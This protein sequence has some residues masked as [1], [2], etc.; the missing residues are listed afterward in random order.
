MKGH[1][2]RLRL[3]AAY[4]ASLGPETKVSGASL[5]DADGATVVGADVGSGGVV[6]VYSMAVAEVDCEVM[7]TWFLCCPWWTERV[8]RIGI[9]TEAD[10]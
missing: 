10:E 9:T 7:S 3:R 8:A 1:W 5:G 4:L 6:L 2:P